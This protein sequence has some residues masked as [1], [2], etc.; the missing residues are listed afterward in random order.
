MPQV[1]APLE[2]A[3]QQRT[4]PA[5]AA[6]QPE[7]LGV[8]AD[9]EVKRRQLLLRAQ[10]RQQGRQREVGE[11][12][13]V[14]R[15]QPVEHGRERAYARGRVTVGVLPVRQAGVGAGGLGRAASVEGQVRGGRDGFGRVPALPGRCRR[16][17]QVQPGRLSGAQHA[18]PGRALGGDQGRDRVK[19]FSLGKARP[20]GLLFKRRGRGS[21]G[22]RVQRRPRLRV[23]LQLVSQ[24]LK[25]NFG[26]AQAQVRLRTGVRRGRDGCRE[27][28]A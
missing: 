28:E 12:Y 21:G 20:C 3:E 13:R 16:R 2:I 22:Q 6:Q 7:V 23:F 24:G 10:R 15:R 26:A 25:K 4:A 17:G 18:V 11:N 27:K 1:D 8:A 14:V 19:K 5:G 9:G